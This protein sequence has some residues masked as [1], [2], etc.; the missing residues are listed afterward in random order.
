MDDWGERL[1]DALRRRRVPKLY[2]LA[3]EI[4][5]D[6][7]AISRWRKGHPISLP[8]AVAL[9]RAL[10]VSLDWLLMGRGTMDAHRVAP[11]DPLML[12]ARTLLEALTAPDAAL[13]REMLLAVS[14]A[15]ADA[16]TARS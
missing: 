5:V 12:A 8:N 6:E 2:A 7:S 9:C 11:A 16:A 10:D 1:D 14:R 13:V 3:V 4:G 15:A